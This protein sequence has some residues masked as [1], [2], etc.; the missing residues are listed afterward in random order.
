MSDQKSPVSSFAEDRLKIIDYLRAH[1]IGPVGGL[2]ETLREFPHKRYL[3]GTL[4]AENATSSEVLIEEVDEGGGG[5][6][7]DELADDPVSMANSW[8]PSSLGLSFF[9]AAESPI[10]CGVWAARYDAHQPDVAS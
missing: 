9:I 4:Y 3:M 6:D 5:S 10:D 8:L 1:S 7:G 2:D